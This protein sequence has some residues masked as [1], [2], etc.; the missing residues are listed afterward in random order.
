MQTI[1]APPELNEAEPGTPSRVNVPNRPPWSPPRGRTPP[2]LQTPTEAGRSG[3][4]PDRL[5]RE[6]VRVPTLAREWVTRVPTA[7]RPSA[8]CTRLGRTRIVKGIPPPGASA[9][10]TDHRRSQHAT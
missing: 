7:P 8:Y 5:G 3:T 10:V 6:E 1:G 9:H 2:E 4:T